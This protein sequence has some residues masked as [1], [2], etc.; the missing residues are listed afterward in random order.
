L[1]KE[2]ASICLVQDIPKREVAGSVAVALRRSVKYEKSSVDLEME[3]NA[4]SAPEALHN[5]D[6]RFTPK[7]RG[8]GGIVRMRAI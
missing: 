7:T 1:I 6:T 2:L 5:A 8:R 3:T 4:M